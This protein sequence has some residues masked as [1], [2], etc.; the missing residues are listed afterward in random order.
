MLITMQIMNNQ[1]PLSNRREETQAT[2]FQHL[3]NT[4]LQRYI[5]NLEFGSI[6]ISGNVDV[7]KKL[8]MSELNIFSFDLLHI[9]YFVVFT[10]YP[11]FYTLNY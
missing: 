5:E 8:S 7:I 6:M 4:Y 11:N 10:K 2:H 9:A 1:I 3:R